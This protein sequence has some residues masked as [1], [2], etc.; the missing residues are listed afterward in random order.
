MESIF[1]KLF[2]LG[3]GKQ[4]EKSLIIVICQINIIHILFFHKLLIKLEQLP[5]CDLRPE[6]QRM[7]FTLFNH[8]GT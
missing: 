1:L 4:V 6:I 2:S 3:S 8:G 5:G 7:L